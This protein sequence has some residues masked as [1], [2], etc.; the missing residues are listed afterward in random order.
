MNLLPFVMTFLMLLA[1]MSYARWE[2]FLNFSGFKVQFEHYIRET[3]R[4]FYNA[5]AELKY[6]NTKATKKEGNQP[7]TNTDAISRLSFYPI[8]HHREDSGHYI[9]IAKNLIKQLYGTH[10]FYKEMEEK[11][12]NFLEEIFARLPVAYQN[13]PPQQKINQIADLATFDLGSTELNEVFCKMLKGTLLVEEKKPIPEEISFVDDESENEHEE[14]QEY[15]SD[16]GYYSLLDY[17]S[18]QNKKIRV[19]LASQELLLA[20][21]GD[22]VIVNEIIQQRRNLYRVAK[23]KNATEA[24]TLFENLFKNKSNYTILDFSVSTTNPSLYE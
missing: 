22:P 16:K 12:P 9:A 23:T 7:K 21:F 10:R 14:E 24:T 1:L 15:V 11:N 18:L 20:I 2:T 4:G 13:L 6:K 17:I 3:E 19:Y 8:L 5:Q